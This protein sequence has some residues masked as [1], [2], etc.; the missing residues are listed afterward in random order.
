MQKVKCGRSLTTKQTMAP[1]T[2]TE[3]RPI[4]AY[5]QTARTRHH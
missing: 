2:P 5:D 1:K 4:P 3:T